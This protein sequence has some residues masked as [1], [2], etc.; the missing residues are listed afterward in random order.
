MVSRL[1]QK[2]G[3]FDSD[4]EKVKEQ[5]IAKL[6]AN[7]Q[8]IGKGVGKKGEGAVF[9]EENPFTKLDKTFKIA[10]EKP[11]PVSPTQGQAQLKKSKYRQEIGNEYVHKTSQ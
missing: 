4:L 3:S 2:L 7:I 9:V 10:M 6:K 8:S 5:V 1:Q 11:G